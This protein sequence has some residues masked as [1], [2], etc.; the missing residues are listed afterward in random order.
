MTYGK[1]I[2]L[3]ETDLQAVWLSDTFSMLKRSFFRM[4]MRPLSKYQSGWCL[5][6]V[7]YGL[8]DDFFRWIFSIHFPV[9]G[10]LPR[11]R[12]GITMEP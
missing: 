5:M 8:M 11:F 3:A 10:G 12:C 1:A 6:A 7:P 2:R 4:R 9:D